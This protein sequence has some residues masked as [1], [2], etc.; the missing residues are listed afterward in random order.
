LD[1]ED[2][3]IIHEDDDS[4]EVTPID[5]TADVDDG[6]DHEP[7][8]DGTQSNDEGNDSAEEETGLDFVFHLEDD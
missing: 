7:I 3:E 2:I 4:T 8:E 6:E 1:Q 5:D